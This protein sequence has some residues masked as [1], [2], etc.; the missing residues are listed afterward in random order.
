SGTTEAARSLHVE[1]VEGD[2]IAP[3]FVIPIA[4][5]DGIPVGPGAF[6]QTLTWTPDD[7]FPLH[8]L[9]A[10]LEGP[11]AVDTPIVTSLPVSV[12]P[13]PVKPPPPPPVAAVVSPL[14]GASD[15]LLNPVFTWVARGNPDLNTLSLARVDGERVVPLLTLNPQ[16]FRAQSTGL[17]G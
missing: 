10:S 17:V 6:S 11:T 15:V 13:A 7:R 14:D 12:G 1:N 8:S 5:T 3:T 9:C 16:T 2:C 4:P